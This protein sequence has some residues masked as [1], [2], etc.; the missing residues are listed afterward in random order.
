MGF[1]DPAHPKKLMPRMKHLL[2]RSALSRDEVDMLR[3]VC[4]AMIAP[5][6]P[7]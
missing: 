2:T 7:K 3:G 4:T 6:R 5:N 1:L